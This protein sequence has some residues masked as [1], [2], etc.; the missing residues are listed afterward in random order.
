MQPCSVDLAAKHSLDFEHF[1]DSEG[2]LSYLSE[3]VKMDSQPISSADFA[4][5]NYH[6]LYNPVY[7]SAVADVPLSGVAVGPWAEDTAQWTYWQQHQPNAAQRV[8]SMPSATTVVSRLNTRR[9]AQHRNDGKHPTSNLSLFFLFLIF[10]VLK[11]VSWPLFT[12]ASLTCI[13]R[14]FEKID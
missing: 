1:T 11:I 6:H 10:L 8:S 13:H 2:L 12:N 9:L 14:L 3:V 5:M 7:P 4:S